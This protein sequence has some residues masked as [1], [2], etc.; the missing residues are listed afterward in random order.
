MTDYNHDHNQ[1]GTVRE[2]TAET[3][4]QEAFPVLRELRSHLEP[5]EMEALYEQMHEEGYRLF[6]RYDTAGDLV[7]VAGVTLGTNFYLGRHVFVHDLVTTEARRSE[8]HGKVLLTYIHAWAADRDC[9]TVELES[10]LW[11]EEAHR[12]YEQLDYEKYC[13]SFK[14]EVTGDESAA[15]RPTGETTESSDSREDDS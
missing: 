15:A 13:Y 5:E 6:G 9:D 3:D 2:L 10:G 1:P 8:G 12:F 7:A 14:Y 4:I 11:R